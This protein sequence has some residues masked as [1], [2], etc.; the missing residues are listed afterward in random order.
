MPPADVYHKATNPDED[1]PNA[2]NTGQ[3]DQ[4]RRGP[5]VMPCP[6]LSL[7]MSFV[8]GFEPL[9]RAPSVE[10]DYVSAFIACHTPTRLTAN[11]AT[12]DLSLTIPSF[13]F[14]TRR[15][16]IRAEQQEM[17]K[18]DVAEINGPFEASISNREV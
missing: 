6:R 14:A 3:F 7:K 2:N 12:S 4:P 5:S 17:I 16:Q 11:F 15:H 10:T 1:L 9:Q 8:T 18:P 13:N